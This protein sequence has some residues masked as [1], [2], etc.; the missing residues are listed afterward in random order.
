MK[1]RVFCDLEGLAGV[2]RRKV[3]AYAITEADALQIKS[4]LES[5]HACTSAGSYGAINIWK[6]DAGEIRGEAMQN[7]CSLEVC[8]FAT[9]AKAAEWAQKWLDRINGRDIVETSFDVGLE[10]VIEKAITRT[11]STADFDKRHEISEKVKTLLREVKSLAW[12]LGPGSNKGVKYDDGA[13]ILFDIH[14][15]IRHHLWKIKPEPK[16]H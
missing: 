4:I 14:Q 7:L 11:Y 6:T 12:N 15:V 5:K 13:D 8:I 2:R 1:E 9:Y 16:Y 3:G 10:E